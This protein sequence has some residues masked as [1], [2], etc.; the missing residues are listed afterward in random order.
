MSTSFHLHF[1]LPMPAH[2]HCDRN[3][4]NDAETD[5]E[6]VQMQGLS[7]LLSLGD[8]SKSAASSG[9]GQRLRICRPICMHLQ[10]PASRQCI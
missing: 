5:L 6:H 9:R 8:N 1:T 7:V 2:K 4:K 3:F 10:M